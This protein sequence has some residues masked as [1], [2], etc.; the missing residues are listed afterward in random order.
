MRYFPLVILLFACEPERPRKFCVHGVVYLSTA[1]GG[2]A[3]LYDKTG[4][5]V[6]CGKITTRDVRSA[7]P[8]SD[9][10]SK[11]ETDRSSF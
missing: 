1:M 5:V 4:K 7:V 10:V 2:L 3:P 8:P 11:A 9:P 6:S